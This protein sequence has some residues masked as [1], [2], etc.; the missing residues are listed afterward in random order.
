MFP[1]LAKFCS[2]IGLIMKEK[3]EDTKGVARRRMSKKNKQYNDQ[4]TNNDLQN[5]AQKTKDRATRTP[6]KT[7]DELRC[8]GIIISSCSTCDTRFVT[9]KR[10]KHHN[11]YN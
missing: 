9:D 11:S 10:H 2:D 1:T 6:S 3:L 4:K 7:V 5:N 8:S